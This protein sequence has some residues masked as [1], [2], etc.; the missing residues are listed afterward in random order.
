M[1]RLILMIISGTGLWF[2]ISCD[3]QNTGETEKGR[4]DTLAHKEIEPYKGNFDTLVIAGTTDSAL[5]YF[6][7][8]YNSEQ[9]QVILAL[10]RIDK[11]HLK[12]TDTLVV[13][14]SV[15][16]DILVYTPFPA[17]LKVAE[18]I[19][20]LVF[21]SYPVQAFAVYE[22]G[23]QV[24]WGP[25]SMGTEQNPT[26]TG[27]FFANWK[28]EEHIST[29]DDEWLLK[30]NFNIENEKGVGWHLYAMPGKPASHSCLRLLEEDAR[31]LYDWA[32]MWELE[33][34]HNVL[35]HGTPVIVFGNYDFKGRRPWL[36]LLDDPEGNRIAADELKAQ[37]EPHLEK[38]REEQQRRRQ[39]VQSQTQDSAATG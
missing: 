23:V 10:N 34:E 37:L 11:H 8:R 9:Q 12:R 3:G 28:A 24:R 14:D 13:P 2:Y 18:N 21:F 29:V 30:W 32:D 26:P 35:A 5:R 33:G 27:L 38:I 17:R 20:K 16:P 22:N 36:R 31:W 19:P 1:K 7:Q 15:V 6:G 4:T 39:I 25:T